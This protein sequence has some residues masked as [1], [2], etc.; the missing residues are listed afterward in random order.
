MR[1]ER[2]QALV[3]F[4][5]VLPMICAML[6]AVLLVAE[7]G[8]A[9]LALEHGAAEGARTGALTNDDALLRGTVAAA[10]SPLDA[11]KVHVSID[12]PQ[13]HPPRTGD[14]RGALLRVTLRYT[15]P[16]P[17]AFVG[18]SSLAIQGDAARRIEWSP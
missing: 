15:I 17:L 16:M 6:L 10:V 8:V 7:I 5:L 2:G 11:A 14:P 1:A 3:E 13:D 9:R 18:L 12:P 4:A